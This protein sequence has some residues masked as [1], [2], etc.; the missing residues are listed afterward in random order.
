MFTE[1][2]NSVTV[3]MA[4]IVSLIDV[5]MR[6]HKEQMDKQARQHR[7]QIAVL[8]E[9]VKTKQH[10]MKNLIEATSDRFRGSSA[11][12]V[13]FQPIDSS[14][15][16]WL[17]YLERFRT[18]LTANSIPKKKEAYLFLTNQSTVTCKLL[19]NVEATL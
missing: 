17:D 2:E 8:K 15:E 13:S 6:Q 18:S 4:D 16:L 19:S 7:E 9:Q 3:I 12:V 11:P 14:S 1:F 10:E 5:L